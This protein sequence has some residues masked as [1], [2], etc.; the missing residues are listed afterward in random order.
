MEPQIILPEEIRSPFGYFTIMKSI[1]EGKVKL[2]EISS[3]MHTDSRVVSKHLSSLQEMDLV[4]RKIPVTERKRKSRKGIY[5]IKDYF[6]RFWFRYVFGNSHL[7]ETG[8]S[9]E[10]LNFI[11]RDFDTYMGKIFEE[12]ILQIIN[13]RPHLIPFKFK[14]AGSFWDGNLEIDIVLIGDKEFLLGEC[15]YSNKPVNEKDFKK[16]CEKSKK[17]PLKVKKIYYAFFSLSG[18][19]PELSKTR[20]PNLMLYKFEEMVDG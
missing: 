14:K 16:L 4:E 6:F 10:L 1:G 7:I 11:K 12:V 3:S 20:P 5:I 13:Q 9:G 2:S 15:K 8:R 18:F 19:S 17:F